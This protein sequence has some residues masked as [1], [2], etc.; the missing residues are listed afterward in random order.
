MVIERTTTKGRVALS[1]SIFTKLVKPEEKGGTQMNQMP[2]FCA[3]KKRSPHSSIDLR[4]ILCHVN[5]VV[6]LENSVGLIALDNSAC[7]VDLLLA[8]SSALFQSSCCC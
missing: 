5:N 2:D 3:N 1:T 7:S 8:V 6:A 4:I